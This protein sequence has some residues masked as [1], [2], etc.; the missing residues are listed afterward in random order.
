V[1]RGH[2][3]LSEKNWKSGAGVQRKEEKL[4]EKMLILLEENI[5]Q[6]NFNG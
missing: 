2:S 4:S 1:L 5:F 3:N 6:K